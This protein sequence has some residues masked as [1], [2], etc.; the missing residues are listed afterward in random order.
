MNMENPAKVNSGPWHSRTRIIFPLLGLVLSLFVLVGGWTGVKHDRVRVT[1]EEVSLLLFCSLLF[2][3]LEFVALANGLAAWRTVPGKV[4]I[5]LSGIML[6]FST[7]LFAWGLT[8]RLDR[9]DAGWLQG[10]PLWAVETTVLMA[11]S[12][13]LFG[14]FRTGT[15]ARAEK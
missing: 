15:I 3:I 12:L 10:T 13:V 5:G 7:F 11:I 8:I 9:R 14:L 6:V 4:A 1:D 2:L